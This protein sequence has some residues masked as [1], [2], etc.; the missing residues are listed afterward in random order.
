MKRDKTQ[1]TMQ[2][3]TCQDNVTLTVRSAMEADM[4]D[5]LVDWPVGWP[6]GRHARPPA[7]SSVRSFSHPLDSQPHRQTANQAAS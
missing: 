3:T 7:R 5:I 2:T 4:G 6:A 1:T